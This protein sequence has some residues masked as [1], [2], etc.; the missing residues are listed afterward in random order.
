MHSRFWTFCAAANIFLFLMTLTCIY[1]NKDKTARHDVSLFVRNVVGWGDGNQEWR[2]FYEAEHDDESYAA[3]LP[4]GLEA[5]GCDKPDRAPICACLAEAHG[6][7]CRAKAKEGVVNCFMNVRPVVEVEE[8]DQYMNVYALLDSLNLW[9]MLGSVVLW[10]RMYIC[11]DDYAMPYWIQFILGL[12]AAIIH[13]S[14]LESYLGAYV[15]YILLTCLMCFL[16]Y[17]HRTDKNWWL[18]MYMLQYLFTVPNLTILCFMAAQKRD[19]LY[20]TLGSLLA[21]AYGFTAF[22]RA[23]IDD[24]SLDDV[25]MKGAR[26]FARGALVF[27]M[28]TLTVSAYDDAGHFYFRSYHATPFG[29]GA[30]LVLLFYLLLGLL[31]PNNLKRVVFADFAIRFMVSMLMVTELFLYT[32][33]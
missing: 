1:F 13:C 31:C 21:A 33:A 22:G 32:S 24:T 10:I 4:V 18:S 20:V 6:R 19:A 27:I 15:V 8:L 17:Y 5:V 26:N 11:N 7:E 16:S 9:G 14:V 28:L 25:E 2:A 29:H 3:F 30:T 12:F 23:L